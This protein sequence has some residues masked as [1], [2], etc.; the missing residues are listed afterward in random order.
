TK[1][2]KEIRVPKHYC[3]VYAF[4]DGHTEEV[5]WQHKSR[6]ESWTPEMKQ[7]ARENARRQAERRK[8]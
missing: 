2:I 8:Q 4:R 1:Q 5:A 3:L 7:K 6:R